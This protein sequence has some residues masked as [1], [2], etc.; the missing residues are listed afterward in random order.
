MTLKTLAGNARTWTSPFQHLS[1][2]NMDIWCNI[3]ERWRKKKKSTANTF[4]EDKTFHRDTGVC[5]GLGLR[6]WFS[7]LSV[8]LLRSSPV[9]LRA[10]HHI[11]PSWRISR[12]DTRHRKQ[13]R[14]NAPRWKAPA[15][16][17]ELPLQVDS[18][19]RPK[20]NNKTAP[21]PPLKLHSEHV[22]T[23]GSVKRSVEEQVFMH[24]IINPKSSYK[25]W[26]TYRRII[27][28]VVFQTPG[29]L[30]D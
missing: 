15:L 6:G 27:Y 28:A 16:S 7:L 9:A 18:K 24:M 11:N 30:H 22:F 2:I 14:R 10:G 17:K 5:S 19:Q 21:V 20:C 25:S 1:V 12:Q 13:K 8:L 23:I 4:K 26:E 29:E 3:Q